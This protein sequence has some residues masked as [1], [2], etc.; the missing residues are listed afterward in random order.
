M[1]EIRLVT[2]G[3]FIWLIPGFLFPK[4]TNA[5]P[6]RA[7][8]SGVRGHAQRFV[9][10]C[11]SRSAVDWAAFWGVHI[12]EKKF[13]RELP[14]SDNPD[15]GFVGNPHSE[16]GNIPP[17][18][19]GVHAGP[20]ASLLRDYGLDAEAKRDL[21]WDDLRV[22]IAAGH[23]VIV[24]VVG[25]MWRGEP[26]RYT[27]SDGQTTIVSRYEHTMILIGYTP[28]AVHLVDAFSGQ[29]QVYP[30]KQFLASWKTLG[31][32]AV[33]GR[34]LVVVEAYPH[35][36]SD[37]ETDLR[38]RKISTRDKNIDQIYLPVLYR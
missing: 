25:Q 7:Y 26:I 34:G 32:M 21:S 36:P 24:W 20:V 1:S 10:S 5:L 6:D 11:E 17:L 23:P 9:L 27:P 19:Y 13:L 8:I 16:W 3:L 22:E 33:L 18:S 38:P 12:G 30:F 29:I 35:R 14:R 4:S 2:F 37:S 15:K 28:N 31:K